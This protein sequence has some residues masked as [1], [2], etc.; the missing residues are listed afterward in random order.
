MDLRPA[1]I[2]VLISNVQNN[3][4]LKGLTM[5]RKKLTDVE[6]IEVAEKLTKNDHLERL[7]LEG[8]QLGPETLTQIAKLIAENESVRLIDL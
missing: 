8:N 5:C 1:Q 2:K 3:G 6:G 4:S 7:E